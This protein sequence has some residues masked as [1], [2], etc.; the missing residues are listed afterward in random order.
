VPSVEGG[1]TGTEGK[2]WMKIAGKKSRGLNHMI[3]RPQA[4]VVGGSRGGSCR[5]VC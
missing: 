2:K 4:S 3:C 5:T 1:T